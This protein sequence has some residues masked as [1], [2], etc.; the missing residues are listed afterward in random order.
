MPLTIFD[1]SGTAKVYAGVAAGVT[2]VKDRMEDIP[3]PLGDRF[4]LMID[5]V[6]RSRFPD[7]WQSRLGPVLYPTFYNF[8]EG[9]SESGGVNYADT[10]VV[11]RAEQIKSYVGSGNREIPLTFQFQAQGGS[12][13]DGVETLNQEVVYPA[14]W[15]DALK[16]PYIREDISHPPPPVLLRLGSLLQARCIATDVTVTWKAPF[17]PTAMLPY[18]AEVSCTFTVVREVIGNYGHQTPQ[19]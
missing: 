18:A 16:H 9:I 14:K 12:G 6:W 1:T 8:D 15:L 7:G 11:G 19:R 17:H 10:D 3:A 5:P 4:S 13:R 2:A